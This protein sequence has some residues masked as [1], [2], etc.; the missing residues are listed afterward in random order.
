M[1]I[2]LDSNQNAKICDFGLA[3]Q[4]RMESTTKSRA[5]ERGKL[6][7]LFRVVHGV[8]QVN[9]HCPQA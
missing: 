9:P 7:P 8:Y 4:M 3:H 2:L 6:L 1:N 5:M